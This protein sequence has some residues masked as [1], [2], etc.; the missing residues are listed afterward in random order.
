MTT[1]AETNY[2]I[3]TN[4]TIINLANS[5]IVGIY[6][7]YI[8]VVDNFYFYFFDLN[9]HLNNLSFRHNLQLPCV[10]GLIFDKKIVIGDCLYRTLNVWHI[11]K[12][13]QEPSLVTET[14]QEFSCMTVLMNGDLAISWQA[15]NY[16]IVIFDSYKGSIK[17]IFIGHTDKISQILQRQDEYIVS[18][19]IDKCVIIWD[20]S[21]NPIKIIKYEESVFS[22]AISDYLLAAGLASNQIKVINL[23][24]GKEIGSFDNISKLCKEQ[25]L[26]FLDNLSILSASEDKTLKIWNPDYLTLNSTITFNSNYVEQ[27]FHS[28]GILITKSNTEIIIWKIQ[29]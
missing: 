26:H 20:L 5:S 2:E 3:I 24:N 21:G 17:N 12:L 8:I 7:N 23:K 28:N 9:L 14:D 11:N 18:S 10:F 22:I 29:L 1:N 4:E 16:D 25:C 6:E 15:N 13:N 27:V 19:S